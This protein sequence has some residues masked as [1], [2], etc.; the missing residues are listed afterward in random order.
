MIKTTVYFCFRKQKERAVLDVVKVHEAL[1]F[2]C[3]EA[4]HYSA[5]CIDTNTIS[6]NK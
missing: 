4:I 2:R 3:Y 6:L 1:E 5:P